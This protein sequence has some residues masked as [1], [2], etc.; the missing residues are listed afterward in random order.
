M[1]KGIGFGEQVAL[2][3]VARLPGAAVRVGDLGY[4]G[5]QVV[6]FVGDG[7]AQRVGF[8]EQTGEFKMGWDLRP[9]LF[10]LI[11]KEPLSTAV[12]LGAKNAERHTLLIANFKYSSQS[13][14]RLV[15]PL[16]KRSVLFNYTHHFGSLAI[17]PSRIESEKL[18]R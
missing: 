5:G 14:S 13:T 4:Q 1:A 10:T 6:V 11:F 9:S 8:F 12:N 3:V 17:Q 18:L 7:A 16:K 15:Y 2:V